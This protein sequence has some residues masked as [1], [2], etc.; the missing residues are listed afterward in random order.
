MSSG[1][2]N[3]APLRY[4]TKCGKQLRVG[5]GFCCACGSPVTAPSS[6]A[7]DLFGQAGILALAK[8]SYV[9]AMP[10]LQRALAI[11]LAPNDEVFARWH[12]AG[13][14]RELFGNSG[15]SYRQMFETKE[16]RQSM[17]EIERAFEL[18][19]TYSL[20]FF[21]QPHMTG[22][23]EPYD[24]MY[25]AES[26]IKVEREGVDAASSYLSAKLKLVDYLAR[27]PLLWSLLMMAALN[28]ERG[29]IEEAIRCLNTVLGTKPLY[30]ADEERNSKVRRKAHQSLMEIQAQFPM[31]FQAPTAAN[32][33]VCSRCST[34]ISSDAR[35][36]KTCGTA[37][38]VK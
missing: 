38:D 23:L 27:P 37:V 9:A 15:L 3:A 19:R 10:L 12:L 13:A 33:L 2:T 14:Y 28:Q 34:A 29:A 5:A 17:S 21:S 18:D 11:G 36:C 22:T 26:R 25:E 7:Q 32:T 24:T 30:P 4:C 20:G 8:G 16:F 6:E 31:Y 1:A 35:F